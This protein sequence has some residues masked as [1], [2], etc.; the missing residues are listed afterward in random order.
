[1][2][3]KTNIDFLKYRKYTF[4]GSAII[5]TLGIIFYIINGGF[6]LGLDFQGGIRATIQ[7]ESEENIKKSD[8]KSLLVAELPDI[9]VAEITTEENMFEITYKASAIK[10]KQDIDQQEEQM[11]EE[12]LLEERVDEVEDIEEGEVV[13]EIEDQEDGTTTENME[14]TEEETAEDEEE[15]EE[16]TEGMELLREIDITEIINQQ[17]LPT[18][19]ERYGEGVIIR[20]IGEEEEPADDIE[21]IVNDT[22]EKVEGL[23]LNLREIEDNKYIFKPAELPE[24]YLLDDFVSMLNQTDLGVK[25]NYEI[26]QV[27]TAVQVD[28]FEP[29]VGQD[30]QNIAWA[31]A[32][33]II[34]LILGY[35][36]LRFQFK[37]GVAAVL[38]VVHDS[39]IILS[40]LAITGFEV[41]IQTV[42]AVLTIIGYSL[43]DTIVVF[44]R[45]RENSENIKKEEYMFVINK[46]IN[47]VIGRT[48]ITSVTTL[49][50]VGSLLVFGGPAI[51]E[52]AFSITIGIVVGTY[53]SI[54]I[55]SPVLIIWENFLHDFHEKKH[56]EKDQLFLRDIRKTRNRW[57]LLLGIAAICAIISFIIVFPNQGII[58][59][60]IGIPAIL[61][62]LLG[63]VLSLEVMKTKVWAKILMTILNLLIV[64][65]SVLL[66]VFMIPSALS[67]WGSVLFLALALVL[68]I[69]GGVLL[70]KLLLF[71][72]GLN[73][74]FAQRTK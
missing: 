4:I 53:S 64:G 35:L 14:E 59:I 32:G 42:T 23:I 18:L 17:V 40:I 38:A 58:S 15:T 24:N 74:S 7:I 16:P 61:L 30:I 5:I 6:N 50:A 66:A 67:N 3:I 29:T 56:K 39:L 55:A 37:F 48:I 52:L 20:Y 11:V 2:K 22:A 70:F 47:E 73:N 19:R 34:L 43:N 60:I 36:A 28:S 25:N 13:E 54:F 27:V 72:K 10:E 21:T 9:E 1:V 51:F 69:I 44:D 8:I 65:A 49:L 41:G 33:L 63:V 62:I 68:V 46:S 31:V 12:E 26:S 57:A 45:I 71:N